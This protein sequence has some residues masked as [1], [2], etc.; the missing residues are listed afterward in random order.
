[1]SMHT[2]ASSLRSTYGQT[3]MR[4]RNSTNSSSIYNRQSL[5]DRTSKKHDAHTVC[6][7]IT[8]N[9]N[10]TV[11]ETLLNGLNGDG[12]QRKDMEVTRSNAAAVQ[13][14]RNNFK[15]LHPELL[16]CEDNEDQVLLRDKPT[17]VTEGGALKGF[18]INQSNGNDLTEDRTIKQPMQTVI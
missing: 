11:E 13:W 9:A 17:S 1:M 7:L 5:G 14:Q 8:Y 4:M 10:N 15:P 3:P 6:N 2:R 16:E 18:E 12:G